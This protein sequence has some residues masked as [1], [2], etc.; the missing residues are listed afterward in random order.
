MR[1]IWLALA[2][3]LLCVEIGYGAEIE[4]PAEVTDAVPPEAAAFFFA[5]SSTSGMTS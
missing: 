3:V 5:T 4:I 2:A 1:R